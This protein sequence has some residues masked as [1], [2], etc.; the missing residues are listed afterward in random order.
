[1][2]SLS[3]E[4][5]D[6]MASGTFDWDS[7]TVRAILFDA[8]Q[9]TDLDRIF[10]SEL[11]GEIVAAGRLTLTNLVKTR[12]NAADRVVC[13]ADTPTWTDANFASPDR[14]VLVAYNTTDANSWIISYHPVRDTAGN[15]IVPN[16]TDLKVPPHP[17]TG[18][19]YIMNAA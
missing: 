8:T 10:L 18:Y 1:M 19:V 13:T 4:A 9:P 7:F 11:T 3:N 15:P 17:A 16:G 2:G 12:D 14:M 5:K 6:R